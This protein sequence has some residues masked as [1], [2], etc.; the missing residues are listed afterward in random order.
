MTATEKIC[1][2]KCK[3]DCEEVRYEEAVKGIY[4]LVKHPY[5]KRKYSEID[6]YCIWCDYHFTFSDLP[7]RTNVMMRKEITKKS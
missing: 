2:P 4:S 7:L 6:F 3:R 5:V 1:C